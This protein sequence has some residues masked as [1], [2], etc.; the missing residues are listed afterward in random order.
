MCCERALQWKDPELWR[1]VVD[2]FVRD[3]GLEV[4]PDDM[5]L[6]A[7][8]QFG[9]EAVRPSFEAMLEAD[10]RNAARLEFLATLSDWAQSQGEAAD[11][12]QPWIVTQ[13]QAVLASLRRPEDSE[14]A[15]LIAAARANGG[16]QFLSAQ[17]LPQLQNLA[18]GPFFLALALAVEAEPSFADPLK[19]DT[20]RALM[21]LALEKTQW[22]RQPGSVVHHMRP[23]GS[24][25]RTPPPIDHC[26]RAQAFAGA[27]IRFGY[28][29]LAGAMFARVV[30][31]A[32]ASWMDSEAQEVAKK[33]MLPLVG[34]VL[35]EEKANGAYE[36]PQEF[37]ELRA[38]TVRI[39]MKLMT[40]NRYADPDMGE[41][42]QVVE[43]AVLEDGD[44]DIFF[45]EMMPKLKPELWSSRSTRP[46]VDALRAVQPRL[47][48]TDKDALDKAIFA[49]AESYTRSAWLPDAAHVIDDLTWA[50][51]VHPALAQ[52]GLD[53]VLADPESWTREH[54]TGLLLPLLPQLRAWT[55][56]HARPDMFAPLARATVRA[57]ADHVFAV[58][59]AVDAAVAAAL[60][61]LRRWTCACTHCAAA[62]AFLR[63]G[64][65][66]DMQFYAVGPEAKRHVEGQVAAYVAGVA[67]AREDRTIPV[68][69]RL[70]KSDALH[71]YSTWKAERTR[72]RQM[73]RDIGEDDAE[74]R[75]VLGAELHARVV[76][77]LSAEPPLAAPG[78]AKSQAFGAARQAAASTA[79]RL[80]GNIVR[81]RGSEVAVLPAAKR[82][83]L[84][85]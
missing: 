3:R 31:R 49:L 83:R 39:Y 56:A 20:T 75:R 55:V 27:C 40:A 14:C 9:F 69:L 58:P 24:R 21:Q 60:D 36:R 4:V 67:M 81:T 54:I 47:S 6:R 37:R 8:E 50:A 74:V 61:G 29:D 77:L 72:G 44:A 71:E 11:G 28:G 33:L 65:D 53:R 46:L 42:G 43:A 25:A 62:R 32:Q 78:K 80:P 16:L 51:G 76:T 15:A 19:S 34:F 73:L 64:F 35:R 13:T 68:G 45:S 84:E 48:A 7:A 66:V 5:K 23:L 63:E 22:Y 10:E 59:R 57:W 26:A 70:Y 17:I 38:R 85:S 52:T 79:N 18:P 1:T 12:I 30:Q 2:T 41:I 82:R